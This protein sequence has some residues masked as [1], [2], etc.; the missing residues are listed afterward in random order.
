MVRLLNLRREF[1]RRI[2]HQIDDQFKICAI[3]ISDCVKIAKV[4]GADM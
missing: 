2:E 1:T 3:I 4:I